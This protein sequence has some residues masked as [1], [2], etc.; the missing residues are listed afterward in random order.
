MD[1]FTCETL[2]KVIEYA[3]ESPD[4][5]PDK[6]WECKTKETNGK[7]KILTL[8][9]LENLPDEIKQQFESAGT[10]LTIPGAKVTGNGIKIPKNVKA[11]IE[12]IKKKDNRKL[13]QSGEK[14]VLVVR[15]T[16]TGLGA[17]SS[18]AARLGDSVF[19]TDGDLVNL[20]SQYNACSYG[21]LIFSPL[22][23][24][25]PNWSAPGVY[26]IQVSTSSTADAVIREAVRGALPNFGWD[27][28]MYCLPPGTDGGWIACK[29]CFAFG[30]FL[31]QTNQ[32][33][34]YAHL[35]VHSRCVCQ[36]RHFGL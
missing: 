12:K 27:Y 35:N 34:R 17:P 29:C 22:D 18:T 30:M 9:D 8:E 7:S 32:S 1:D 31:P 15:V 16:T 33:S 19:G 24:T 14:K 4:K 11:K 2:L 26:D 23:P 13:L 3:E 10:T 21:Q 36:L 5:G 28:V 20:R 6:V 25:N